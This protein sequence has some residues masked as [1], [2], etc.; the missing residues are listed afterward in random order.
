MA[1]DKTK[2]EIKVIELNCLGCGYC[3]K[4]CVRDGIV[5]TGDK[6]SAKGFP[7]PT[8][9]NPENCNACGNCRIMC[10]HFAIEVYKYIEAADGDADA[11]AD[12]DGLNNAANSPNS[13]AVANRRGNDND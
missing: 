12:A 4:Y 13:S 6:F 11:D 10:P 5:M 1:K 7:L 8:F 9:V 2:G 3:A